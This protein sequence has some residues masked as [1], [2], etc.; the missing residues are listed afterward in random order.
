MELM[1]PVGGGRRGCFPW[2]DTGGVALLQFGLAAM[3]LY[4]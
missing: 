3:A 2:I 1:T 4:R